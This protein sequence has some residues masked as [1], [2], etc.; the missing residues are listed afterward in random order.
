MSRSADPSDGSYVSDQAIS[1]TVDGALLVVCSL[2]QVV[3][4]AFS[5]LH[6]RDTC[7]NYMRVAGWTFFQLL[8]SHPSQ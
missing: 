8:E 6:R 5:S 2:V 4:V 1:T 3:A 7:D